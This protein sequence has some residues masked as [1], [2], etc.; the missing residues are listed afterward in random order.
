MKTNAGGLDSGIISGAQ[1][2]G[3]SSTQAITK[4]LKNKKQL[5]FLWIKASI[6]DVLD[7]H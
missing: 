4:I 1:E 3:V 6:E 7:Y 2:N 5:F